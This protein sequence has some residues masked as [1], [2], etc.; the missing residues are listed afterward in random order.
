MLRRDKASLKWIYT[1]K[2]REPGIKSQ[3]PGSG[4]LGFSPGFFYHNQILPSAKDM[5]PVLKSADSQ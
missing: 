2:N 1:N 4:F 5:L 3:A